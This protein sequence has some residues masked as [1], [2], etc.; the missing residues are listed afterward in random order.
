[1]N[2]HLINKSTLSPDACTSASGQSLEVVSGG[3]L[4]ELSCYF[5]SYLNHDIK[6]FLI[7]GDIRFPRSVSSVVGY[8]CVSSTPVQ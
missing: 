5:N 1:M 8:C 4:G 7:D 2:T 3:H 6:T